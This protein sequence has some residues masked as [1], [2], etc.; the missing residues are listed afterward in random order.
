MSQKRSEKMYR[1]AGHVDREQRQACRRMAELR[2]ALQQSEQQLEVLHEYLQGYAADRNAPPGGSGKLSSAGQ[3]INYSAFLG[4]LNQAVRQQQAHVDQA[5]IAF[6][7][8][9]ERWKEV[10]TRSL[11]LT[12]VAERHAESERRRFAA[13]EQNQADELTLRRYLEAAG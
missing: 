13:A 2:D 8:Q 10:R 3:L 1:I 9:Q 4:Q 5:R 7:K 11:A 12:Q 6:D